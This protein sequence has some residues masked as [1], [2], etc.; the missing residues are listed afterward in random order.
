MDFTSRLIN[1]TS[2]AR[3]KVLAV[4]LSAILVLSMTNIFAFAT[5]GSSQ[6]STG[7]T[8]AAASEQEVNVGLD[9]QNSFVVVNGQTV[10]GAKVKV[11]ANSDFVFTPQANSGFI[12]SEVK[13]T[14]ASFGAVPIETNGETLII[15]SVYIDDSLVITV[16]AIADTN[17]P[18]SP[19]GSTPLNSAPDGQSGEDAITPFNAGAKN[20][21]TTPAAN[22]DGTKSLQVAPTNDTPELIGGTPTITKFSGETV[23][24]LYAIGSNGLD[25]VVVLVPRSP[26]AEITLKNAVDGITTAYINTTTLIAAGIAV[27]PSYA[28][29]FV[30][31]SDREGSG[32]SDFI[33]YPQLSF[34]FT[35]GST[36]DEAIQPIEGYIYE[37]VIDNSNALI[38]G[39]RV[40][41]S[42]T[43]VAVKAP[44]STSTIMKSDVEVITLAK[45]IKSI[46]DGGFSASGIGG[47]LD[48]RPFSDTGNYSITYELALATDRNGLET[49]RLGIEGTFNIQDE[50]TGFLAS[51]K[52]TQIKID[53]PNGSTTISEADITAEAGTSFAFPIT[54]KL[55]SKGMVANGTYTV[56]VTYDKDDYTNVYPQTTNVLGSRQVITNSAWLN[57]KT[58]ANTS[59]D[60]SATPSAQQN[61][62][63]YAQAAPSDIALQVLKKI[64]VKQTDYN[65][66]EIQQAKYPENSDDENVLV[67][68]KLTA[69]AGEGFIN[70]QL[71]IAGNIKTSGIASLSGLTPNTTYTLTE[72]QG[73]ANFNDG[74]ASDGVTVITGALLNN[75][76]SVTIDGKD[77]TS[78]AYPV[79]N[80]AKFDGTIEVSV[81][82]QK[83]DLAAAGLGDYISVS[84]DAVKV[85]LYDAA[86]GK[87]VASALT[88]ANGNVKFENLDPAKEYTAK[89]ETTISKTT[90]NEASIKAA[91]FDA[92]KDATAAIQYTSTFGAMK[93]SKKFVGANGSIVSSGLTANF[94]LTSKD[95][96]SITKSFSLNAKG[97]ISAAELLN[98]E[99]APGA[100]TLTETSIT[101]G[102]AAQY[103]KL[104]P[105]DVTID[106]GEF[107]AFN[108]VLVNESNY[109][110]IK[111]KN[112]DYGNTALT[113]GGFN[114][115]L[116]YAGGSIGTSV[117]AGWSEVTIDVPAGAYTVTQNGSVSGFELVKG[118]ASVAVTARTA[119]SGAMT[120]AGTA[121]NFT[122]E[123][124]A[125]Q[126]VGFVYASL[127]TV[128]GA[129]VNVQG[130]VESG[131][132]LYTGLSGT[133]FALYKFEGGSYV[134]KSEVTSGTSGLITV[135]N[136][137]EG[138]YRLIEIT[139][140]SGYALPAYAIALNA[141]ATAKTAIAS[142]NLDV[143]KAPVINIAKSDYSTK[144]TKKSVGINT[145]DTP[146]ANGLP[147]GSIPNA[148][149]ACPDIKTVSADNGASVSGATFGLYKGAVL[150]GT[151]TEA[152]A[153]FQSGGKDI[154]LPAGEYT[155]K[156]TGVNADYMLR[157]DAVVKLTVD[158]KGFMTS[159]FDSFR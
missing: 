47:T 56:T 25:A 92:N 94:T 125:E 110:Q 124:N 44:A 23:D 130:K 143:A 114:Y 122:L 88:D 103:T 26:Y 100:Y 68:F 93:I 156:Q 11:S 28:E 146:D 112:F 113:T 24:A 140:T 49:G 71:P 120:V 86:S 83:N 119:P 117:P 61:A 29:Y 118:S 153:K 65:Y 10:V 159:S 40:A 107:S 53:G 17:A 3:T 154:Q 48:S 66:D 133:K 33:Q 85:V 104:S 4:V 69:I 35:N 135:S 19:E 98:L 72:T 1:K 31:T 22:P 2:N 21:P 108:Q 16:L 132:T 102:T 82:R 57:Y 105:R 46:S 6:S 36:P 84:K 20:S 126:T 116:T 70:G 87:A 141:A 5:D 91:N 67:G 55:D 59:V 75:K 89:A 149:F 30:M 131:S 147:A 97:E 129:K 12:L 54:A 137:N 13:A 99:L 101:G 62:I 7:P 128:T 139:A 63:G 81:T 18:S 45:T 138:E 58:K 155:I 109:G 151:A 37:G 96:P 95:N 43:A 134:Y 121:P 115:T 127:P 123:G 79:I 78:E 90:P 74:I 60:T 142:S 64:K 77:Y 27:D 152:S 38:Q 50:L 32:N 158:S 145:S 106:A 34:T 148:P 157:P 14:S 8:S 73:I 52:P 76:V 136:L 80:E 15:R 150:M 42:S 111:I 9:L 144:S 41:V 39:S 51:G